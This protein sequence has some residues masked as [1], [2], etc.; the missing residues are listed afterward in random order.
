VIRAAV[1]SESCGYRAHLARLKG[2]R[3]LSAKNK[4]WPTHPKSLWRA[5]EPAT[6]PRPRSCARGR[7]GWWE[8]ATSRRGD[9]VLMALRFK[10][11]HR[12]P[13]HP[14]LRPELPARDVAIRW[15][16][17][18]CHRAVFVHRGPAFAAPPRQSKLLE[19]IQWRLVHRF[20]CDPRWASLAAVHRYPPG[21]REISRAICAGPM[22]NPRANLSA[23]RGFLDSGHPF[24][25]T[26]PVG[27]R[28]T[29]RRCSV[30]SNA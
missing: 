15:C 10:N 24:T 20:H 3:P 8:V 28:P 12:A 26:R 21:P 17:Y 29:T 23:Y 14:C 30:A 16:E 19:S 25:C 18:R 27:L 7:P 5:D 9:D 22:K 2:A 6:A 4:I 1:I 11:G 13:V